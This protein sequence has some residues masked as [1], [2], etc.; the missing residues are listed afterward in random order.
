MSE[1]ER[2]EGWR[3]PASE[4]P[5]VEGHMTQAKAM[6][7]GIGA[8]EAEVAGHL[9]KKLAAPESTDEPEVEGHVIKHPAAPE[10][11]GAGEP[12]VEGHL[13]RKY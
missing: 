11:E 5:E 3:P 13:I 1:T 2:N 9:Y 10:L 7:E 4:E 6:D 8:G 12:E